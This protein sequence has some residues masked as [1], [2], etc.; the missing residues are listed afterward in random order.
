STHRRTAGTMRRSPALVFPLGIAAFGILLFM[1]AHATAQIDPQ[2]GWN[3][4]FRD[5]NHAAFSHFQ[6]KMDHDRMQ[7]EANLSRAQKRVA[8]IEALSF[9]DRLG[10]GVAAAIQEARAEQRFK[11]HPGSTS[12]GNLYGT[13][14][15]VPHGHY[16]GNN[17]IGVSQ[18]EFALSGGIA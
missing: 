9:S 7:S 12:C 13:S 3:S 6:S 11:D 15:D 4:S 10:T 16:D 17:L 5:M 2:S 18:Q 14:Y 8:E 1:S